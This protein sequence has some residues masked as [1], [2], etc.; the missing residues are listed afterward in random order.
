MS[1]ISLPSSCAF[2]RLSFQSLIGSVARYTHSSDFEMHHR[3][4]TQNDGNQFR[5]S[6]YK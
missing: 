3:Y 1:Y 5:T 4:S 6:T 2:F